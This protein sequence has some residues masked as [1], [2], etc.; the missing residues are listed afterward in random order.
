MAELNKAFDKFPYL[1]HKQTV[2]LAQCCSLHTDQVKA[3]FMAE[4]LR[5]GISWDYKDIQDIRRKLKLNKKN[6]DE[7]QN[8]MEKDVQENKKEKTTKKAERMDGNTK[9]DQHGGRNEKIMA[10][11]EKKKKKKQETKQG[12]SDVQK[13]KYKSSTQKKRKRITLTGKRGKKRMKEENEGAMEKVGKVE[14]NKTESEGQKFIQPQTTPVREKQKEKVNKTITSVQEQPAN[15]SAM[16]PYVGDGCLLNLQSQTQTS[17]PSQ[18]TN[19]Q[20]DIMKIFDEPSLASEICTSPA[21]GSFEG[22]MEKETNH[23]PVVSDSGTLITLTEV[24]NSPVFEEGSSVFTQPMDSPVTYSCAHHV[25]F[26]NTKRRHQLTM[27]KQA[28][29][30]CQY[31]SREQYDH[32]AKQIGIPR[33]SLVQFYRDMRYSIKK[34]KPRW[35]NKEQHQQALANIQYRQLMNALSKTLLRKTNNTLM[36]LKNNKNYTV[37]ECLKIVSE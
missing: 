9:E 33:L 15:Q 21:N 12:L 5:Y 19:N 28:F 11:N 37:E 1:T 24:N 30:R 20:A 3:W 16:V 23:S 18:L 7:P 10:V 4:R 31:P 14:C 6:K 34:G 27:M 8:G 26:H 35:M 13:E 17:S 32:L 2:K 29:L 25:R 36:M 22:K